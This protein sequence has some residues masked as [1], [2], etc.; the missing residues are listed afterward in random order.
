MVS[1]LLH[2]TFSI[3][4]DPTMLIRLPMAR[5]GAA[6]VE[7]NPTESGPRLPSDVALHVAPPSVLGIR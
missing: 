4:A 7:R 3:A 1:P 5:A 2:A 6:R